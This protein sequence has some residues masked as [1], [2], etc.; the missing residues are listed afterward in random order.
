MKPPQNVELM[1]YISLG[2][3][4]AI[5]ILFGGGLAFLLLKKALEKSNQAL[6]EEAKAE[7]EVLRERKIIEAKEKFL[8]L[9]ADHESV[10]NEKNQK[11]LQAEQRVKHKETKLNEKLQEVNKSEN[12]A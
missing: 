3:G 9:K 6:I 8:Q 1:D 7:G 10:I 2:S 12:N 5:G 11:I 4:I